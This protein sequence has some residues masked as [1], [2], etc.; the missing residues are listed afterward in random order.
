MA[1]VTLT[2]PTAAMPR[3]VHALCK[4]A[5]LDESPANAKKAIIE[6]IRRTVRN[7]EMQEAEQALIAQLVEV[8]TEAMVT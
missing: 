7:V 8:D 4:S 1:T 5:G 3:V 6:H 2:I